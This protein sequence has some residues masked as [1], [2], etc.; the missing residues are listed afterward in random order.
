[1]APA[2]HEIWVTDPTWGNHYAL[3]ARAGLT[4]RLY[5]YYKADTKSLDFDGMIE[6]LKGATDGAVVLLHACNHI[7]TGVDPS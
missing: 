6:A 1:M 3:F 5:P 4:V 2:M 7:P